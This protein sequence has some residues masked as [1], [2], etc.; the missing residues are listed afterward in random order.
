MRKGRNTGSPVSA[1]RQHK[2]P[3]ESDRKEQK[4]RIQHTRMQCRVHDLLRM[5]QLRRHGLDLAL[6]VGGDEALR[7]LETG[8][9]D[10]QH[11]AQK[12]ISGRMA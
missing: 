10:K 2:D 9:G 8:A 6:L 12:S 11:P 5:P 1:S 3:V 4:K 7:V